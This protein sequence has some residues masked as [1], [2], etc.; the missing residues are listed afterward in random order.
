MFP[1]PGNPRGIECESV[2]VLHTGEIWRD[3][4]PKS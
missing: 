3:V 4:E 2:V 1:G